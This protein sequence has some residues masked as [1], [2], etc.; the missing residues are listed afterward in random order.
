MLDM[1]SRIT[2]SKSDLLSPNLEL[3]SISSLASIF[4]NRKFKL[5]LLPYKENELRLFKASCNSCNYSIKSKWPINTTNLNIH[6]N[7]K[8]FNLENHTI[9]NNLILEDNSNIENSSINTNTTNNTLNSYFSNNKKRPSFI[10]FSKEDYKYNLLNFI[11]SNNLPF[12]IIES[13]TFNNL[14]KY[15][16]DDLPIIS[17]TTIRRE[18]DIF[19]NLELTKLKKELSINNSLFSLTL[20]EWKSSNNIDFLAITLHYRDSKFNL[21]S[22]LIGFEYLN[23]YITYTSNNLYLT[24]NI[25]LKDFNIRN[26][27]ISITRDNASPINST[28]E[29]IRKKYNI[30][31]NNNIIDIKC[32]AHILNLISNSFLDYTFFNNNTTKKFNKDINN[33][34]EDN[35][36]NNIIDIKLLLANSKALPNIVRTTINRFKYNHFL[37]HLFKKVSLNKR[38]E[39]NSNIGSKILIKDNVTR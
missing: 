19:Y 7:K 18:L 14:I 13:K 5:E 20:D 21:R 39:N 4:R 11:I 16:K 35:I 32:A 2:L 37:K 33:I 38:I 1:P 28:I 6:F 30:K 27:I 24:I 15:L 31:Y 25:I 36:D 9:D 12:S 34:V 17:R 26:K 29:L 23:N 8:H 3:P 22:Y 10:L